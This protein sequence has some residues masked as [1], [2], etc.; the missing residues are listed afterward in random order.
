VTGAVVYE[1]KGRVAVL[2]IVNPPVNAT[3]QAVR[4]GLAAALDRLAADEAAAAAVM[5]GAGR[6]FIGGADI[7]EFGKPPAEPLLPGLVDRIEESDK[8]V[9]AA[10][11]GVAL[12]GGL[13]IALG[14]HWR[15]A[16]EGA[17]LGLPEVTL[18][19]LPGAGG[20]QRLPRLVGLAPALDLIT[21]GRRIGAAEALS[22]GIID[23]LAEG[24][25]IEAEGIA[26]AERLLVT[27]C[28]PRRTSEMPAP[29]ADVDAVE[30]ARAGVSRRMRGQIAPMKAIEAVAAATRRPFGEGKAEERR[31]FGEL[32]RSPQR[33]ALIHAFFAERRAARPREIEGIAPR[34]VERIGVIGGG[35]MGT[36]IAVAALQAGLAVTLVERDAESARKAGERVQALIDRARERGRLR[37]D[38]HVAIRS[39]IAAIP[40]FDSLAAADLVVEAVFENMEVKRD[41]FVRL[42]R[43]ARPGA[44]LATNTSYLDVNA[45]AA[46]TARP[47]DVLGLHFFSPAHVMKLLEVVVADRTAPD[48]TATG[49]ALAKR[50]GK[51]PVRAGV[52]D[53]FIG[54]RILSVYRMAADNMVLD[55]ASPFD[56]DRALV[57]F[58]FAMG[59]YAVADLAGLD[60]GYM[61][62]QRKAATR[63]PRERVPVFAD[64]LCERGLLG[65]KSGRGYYIHDDPDRK[66]EPNPE[67]DA[68]LAEVRA[69]LGITP[70]SFD[71]AEIVRRYMAAMVNEGAR[72]VE[73]GIALR[74]LDVDVTLLH[75]YGFPRWRGGPM[76]WADQTGIGAIRDDIIRFAREDDFFW[77]P[78]RLLDELARTGGR[79]EDLN[80]RPG[81]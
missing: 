7:T 48:V 30:A 24:D 76:K 54:N 75:G 20:T 5:V 77:R 70:R 22:L 37:E 4:A 29:P 21:S 67:V 63:D 81:G 45:I 18:G 57:D 47:E 26:F 73:D 74:P 2:R 65:Q 13:E 23:A 50:L 42:D 32:M 40:D 43:I 72:V 6:A 78:A 11:H 19:I 62:R 41:V 38:Q 33:E 58:G 51:I 31:L 27:G 60:I 44:V 17:T 3:S 56:I 16:G 36:G 12:G 15:I 71:D 35:T 52:C 68:I 53:G 69:E 79:F 55:G 10:I 39:R 28:G 25:D 80:E 66:G 64:R 61:T 46:A 9:V 59:P 14:A 8:P 34:A 1:R 49:F